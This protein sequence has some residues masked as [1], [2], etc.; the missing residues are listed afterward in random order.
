MSGKAKVASGATLFTGLDTLLMVA[1]WPV[2]LL[3]VVPAV[4]VILAFCW[5]LASKERSA[6]LAM[7]IRA[8]LSIGRL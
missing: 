6:R 3:L 4:A 7:L 2:V 8:F 5:I 1:K